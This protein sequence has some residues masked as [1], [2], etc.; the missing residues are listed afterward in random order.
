M[1]PVE[2]GHMSSVDAENPVRFA[3]TAAAE[4]WSTAAVDFLADG[5][6]LTSCELF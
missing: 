6:Q 3:Q 4:G 5:L 2:T 1:F